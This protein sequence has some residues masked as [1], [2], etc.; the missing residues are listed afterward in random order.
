MV[1]I[2]AAFG[3]FGFKSCVKLGVQS[4]PTLD[5]PND[6]GVCVCVCVCVAVT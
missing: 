1:T 2:A 4:F 6:I 5:L 3:G